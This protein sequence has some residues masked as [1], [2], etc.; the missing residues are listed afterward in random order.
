MIASGLC[1]SVIIVDKDGRPL[2]PSPLPAPR[3][4]PASTDPE[5]RR[6]RTLE[7]QGKYAQAAQA[8]ASV[9]R[10]AA[11]ALQSQVRCLLRSGQKERALQVV[12]DDFSDERFERATDLQGRLIV[13]DV[14]RMALDLIGDPADP[15]HIELASRLASRLRDYKDSPLPSSQ[16]LFLMKRMEGDF[17]TLKAEELAA[18]WLET[19][20]AGAWQMQ[21]ARAGLV[22]IWTQESV[23]EE[24]R[25][26][27]AMVPGLPG[28]EVQLLP[29]GRRSTTTVGSPSGM[30][31]KL[32]SNEIERGLSGWRV[33]LKLSDGSPLV[34]EFGRKRMVYVWMALLGI[35]A[36]AIFAVFIGRSVER[37]VRVAHLKSDLVDTVS[38]ELKTPLSS[39]RLLVDTLLET[40]QLN[41]ARTREYLELIAK[42]N[43]R[44][45]HLI[46][47]FLAFSRME[48]GR[49]IIHPR[50]VMPEEIVQSA[51]EAAGERF[52]RDG[53]RLETQVRPG[54]PTVYADPDAMVTV[55]LNLLDNAYKYTGDRKE[56]GLRAYADGGHVCFSVA[57][58]GIGLS[59][60]QAR[61]VFESFYQ[62][63]RRLSRT[64]AGLGLG[65]SIAQ[66]I[67][68]AHGGT[69]SVN[70]TPGEGS[71]FTV[72]V[73]VGVV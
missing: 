12:L 48:K 24:S 3:H 73:P 17:P 2:Y 6:A 15:R 56:I 45:S 34:A 37:Q 53:C 54:L 23:E 16:R 46:E 41:E 51:V 40:E 38:H 8:Y 63:D 72:R 36:L 27:I 25:K 44:L 65:L 14:E 60:R 42:E 50:D 4:D 33:T 29:P 71:T 18:Q 20:E 19:G 55:L 28:I 52:H 22:A 11:R 59:A 57:D 13:A 10:D 70:S 58:N 61:R 39:I 62:A 30:S 7:Q 32:E 67:V 43:K 64:A 26:A 49:E 69:I 47:N 35:G 21:S 66:F 9:S 5:W 31:Y 68:K 1:D